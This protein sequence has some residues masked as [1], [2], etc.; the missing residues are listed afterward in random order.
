M[1]ELLGGTQAVDEWLTPTQG[2]GKPVP[3]ETQASLG[4]DDLI[5]TQEL[6]RYVPPDPLNATQIEQFEREKKVWNPSWY[7]QSSQDES[8]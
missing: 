1:P 8:R 4:A 2:P 6:R 5:P 3:N 7:S